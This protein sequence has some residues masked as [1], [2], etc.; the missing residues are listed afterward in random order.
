VWLLH[1]CDQGISKRE[2]LKRVLPTIGANLRW[3]RLYTEYQEQ[4]DMIAP[5]P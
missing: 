5:A 3:Q 2:F 4:L 1:V